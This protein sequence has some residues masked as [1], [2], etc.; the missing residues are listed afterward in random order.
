MLENRARKIL[1]ADNDEDVLVALERILQDGGYDTT[2]V[3]SSAEA[4][5]LL[6]VGKFDLLVLDDF[7]SDKDSAQILTECRGSGNTLLAVVTYHRFP[8]L[9][10]ETQLRELGVSALVSKSAHSELVAIVDHLLKPY[11]VGQRTAFDSIT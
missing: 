3:L 5:K 8:S 2:T 7:L 6:S 9:D 10:K 1:V 11:T 4:H